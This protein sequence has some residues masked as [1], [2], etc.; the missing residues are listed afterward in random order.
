MDPF[1]GLLAFEDAKCNKRV[2]VCQKN[3]KDHFGARMR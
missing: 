2:S 3:R 1:I